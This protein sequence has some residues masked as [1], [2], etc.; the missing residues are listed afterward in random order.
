MNLVSYY[1]V[2]SLTQSCNQHSRGKSA[3]NE[4]Y[5]LLSQ[6]SVNL[7]GDDHMSSPYDS[8]G[9]ESGMERSE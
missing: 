3:D 7:T 5:A 1:S 2:H 4:N 8:S 9:I 6:H